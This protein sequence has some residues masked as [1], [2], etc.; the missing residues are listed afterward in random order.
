MARLR[1]EAEGLPAGR[2]GPRLN[3]ALGRTRARADG[4]E[5][6]PVEEAETLAGHRFRLDGPR[7]QILAGSMIPAECA[8]RPHDD[9]VVAWPNWVTSGSGIYELS[10][11]L[12]PPESTASSA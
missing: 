1:Y 10:V 5:W 3:L 12:A 8:L 6:V 9:G 4:A 11:D 7:A 2:L